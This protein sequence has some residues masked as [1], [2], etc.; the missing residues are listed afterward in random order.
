RDTGAGIPPALHQRIFD[1]FFTNK[2][3]GKGMG[4]SLAI[5]HHIVSDLGGTIAVESVP[6]K[7][8]IF[9]VTLPPAQAQT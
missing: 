6:D 3:V 9:R 8:S 2:P 1:P 7:G 4:L 5:C